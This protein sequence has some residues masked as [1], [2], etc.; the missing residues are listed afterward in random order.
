MVK[1]S[2]QDAVFV[3]YEKYYNVKPLFSKKKPQLTLDTSLSTGKYPWA[4]ETGD[5]I[6]NDYF[7]RRE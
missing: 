6:L 4:R 2:I 1:D 3:W 7:K 5:D